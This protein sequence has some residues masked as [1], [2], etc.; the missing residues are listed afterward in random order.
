MVIRKATKKDVLAIV[1]L[2]KELEKDLNKILPPEFRM[3]GASMTSDAIAERI[4]SKNFLTLV[5]EENEKLVGLM[6]NRIDPL[7]NN[8]RGVR[9]KINEMY[10]AKKFRGKSIA[11]QLYQEALTW[12]KEN[13]CQYVQLYVYESNTAKDIYEKWGFKP[14]SMTMINRIKESKK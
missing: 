7:G 12:F 11:S 2:S 10:L 5:V 9:G 13:K 14:F 3:F 6:L 4:D 8:K 1:S